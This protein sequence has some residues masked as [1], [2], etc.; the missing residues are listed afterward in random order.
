MSFSLADL[1]DD[2]TPRQGWF[3]LLDEKMAAFQFKPYIPKRREEAAVLGGESGIWART[4]KYWNNGLLSTGVLKP[5]R[6]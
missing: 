6:F 1:W 5:H 3:K 4:V 2:D